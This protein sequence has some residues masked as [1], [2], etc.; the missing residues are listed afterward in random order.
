[1][2]TER[3]AHRRGTAPHQPGRAGWRLVVFLL[4]AAALA[5]VGAHEDNFVE[6]RQLTANIAAS[7]DNPR[8]YLRRAEMQRLLRHWHAAE[9][10]YRRAAELDPKLALVDLAFATLWNDA[11]Q[12]EQALVLLDG[13]LSRSPAGPEGY[14]ERARSNRMLKRWA[15]AAADCAE[16]LKHTPDPDPEVFAA[17]AAVLID[18]GERAQALEVLNR[19]IARLGRVASLAMKALDLEESMA[20]HDAA[21]QR[22]GAMLAAPGRKD[23]LLLR[24]AGILLAAGRGD[25]ARACVVLARQQ[26]NAVPEARRLTAAGRQ[27]AAKIDRLETQTAKTT[28]TQNTNHPPQ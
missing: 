4:W 8:L 27:L 25:E 16:V 26:F 9:A 2:Q 21:L 18:G 10:D 13:Y 14:A 7:P 28:S 24:K 22:I 23:S 6:I 19:G 1:M 5:P 17:W 20:L 11:G 12:P 15:A 3:V